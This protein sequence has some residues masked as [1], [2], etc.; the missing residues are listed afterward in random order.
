MASAPG[1][2]VYFVFLSRFSAEKGTGISCLP[3]TCQ[4]SLFR[5]LTLYA[6]PPA[7]SPLPLHKKKGRDRF[8]MVHQDK[9]ACELLITDVQPATDYEFYVQSY[10]VRGDGP[11]CPITSIRTRDPP[12]SGPPTS[13]RVI[14][15][16]M[17]EIEVGWEPPASD[18]CVITAYWWACLREQFPFSPFAPSSRLPLNH[19]RT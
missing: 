10:G 9:D 16:T 11:S 17:D 18:N 6:P 2:S 3:N 5:C 7:L 13:L 15:A 8:N 4:N 19:M 1:C 12:P 14:E